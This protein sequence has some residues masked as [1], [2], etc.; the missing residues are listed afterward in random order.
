M[1]ALT[2]NLKARQWIVWSLYYQ[3]FMIGTALKQRMNLAP[4]EVTIAVLHCTLSLKL[5]SY[6]ILW[7]DRVI[8]IG[9]ADLF[10]RGDACVV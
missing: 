9:L 6:A 3:M 4:F 2:P 10:K 5:L 1:Y 8:L 7:I